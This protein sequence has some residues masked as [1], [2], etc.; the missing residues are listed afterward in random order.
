MINK[1]KCCKI[2]QTIYQYHVKEKSFKRLNT[3]FDKKKKML[4]KHKNLIKL[5]KRHNKFKLKFSN[6]HE[7]AQELLQLMLQR[8]AEEMLKISND[9]LKTQ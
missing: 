7:L 3:L 5:I 6:I 4:D 2:N 9:F 8:T 1:F